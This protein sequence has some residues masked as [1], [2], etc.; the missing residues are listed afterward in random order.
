MGAS[1]DFSVI[2]V[3]GASAGIG[4][5]TARLFASRG[6]RVALA[7]RRLDRLQSLAVEIQEQGGQALPVAADLGRLDDIQHLVQAVLEHYGQVDILFNNAGF[8]RLDWLEELAP[9]QDVQAQIQVNLLGA[10]WLTQAVLPHMI[11]CRKG[12]I[13]NMSS[14]AGL[15]APPTYSI[16]AASKFGLRGFTEALR[17]EVGI[18]GIHVSG[19]Y[20]G[21]V[22]TEFVEIAGIERRTGVTTPGWLT[23]S[24]DDVA[25]AVLRLAQHPRRVVILP[26]I[27][28]LAVWLNALSPAL[29]DWAVRRLF[30]ERERG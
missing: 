21:G 12:H 26:W 14:M 2:L 24:A 7:A 4:A 18:Y 27:M 15:V 20:P 6:Y 9:E 17:R 22:A 1:S 29:V 30:V 19:I 8:G 3:T 25:R 11:A 28:H 13:I 5:A 16:Y 23:L 10:I